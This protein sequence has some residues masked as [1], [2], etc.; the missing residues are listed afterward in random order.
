EGLGRDRI[1]AGTCAP[2][3]H[4]AS[5]MHG[6]ECRA[7]LAAVRADNGQYHIA[8][9]G[10]QAYEI[11]GR[12][13]APGQISGIELDRGPGRIRKQHGERAGT[14]HPVP[15]VAQPSGVQ[16]EGKARVDTF[17]DRDA[18]HRGELRATVGS[19]E[20]MIG[21]QAGAAFRLAFGTWPL[22]RT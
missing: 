6:D 20:A 8:A 15:L 22:L 18:G 14:T 10:F 16:A 5:P 3:K 9:P 11:A 19:R 13:S 4:G 1:D 12:K 2:A 21:V 17:G 7:W